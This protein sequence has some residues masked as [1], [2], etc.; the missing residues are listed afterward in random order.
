M[1]SDHPFRFAAV[2]PFTSPATWIDTARRMEALGYATLLS[3]DHPSRLGS[4][5]PLGALLLAAS[6]TTRL[7]VGTHVLV[8]DFRNP[9]MLAQ[10][11][12]LLDAVSDGRFELGLGTG[13]LREDYTALGIA[14]D[15][16]GARV[17]RL[18]EAITLIKRLFREESVTF[19][20]DHYR[21]ENVQL[22][23]RPARQ[24]QPLLFI[25]G[26][27]KR[28]LSLAG[29]EADIVSFDPKGTAAGPKDLA[30]TTPAV[31][32]EQLSW[33]RAAA[34]PRFAALELH[35]LVYVVAVTEQR[36]AAAEAI[37]QLLAAL[38]PTMMINTAL[39][40]D[41]VLASPRFLIGSVE[42]IVEQLQERRAQYGI[43][44]I[45]ILSGFGGFA[46]IETFSP[47]VA[48]LAGS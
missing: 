17:G 33:V 10:Q 21:V 41:E 48:R 25:G 24:P 43:S 2:M 18:E 8:N 36:Q 7:R 38:P 46:D 12:V 26:G 42:Q 34:G 6:A 19:A 27:G 22:T 31:L 5:D 47:V 29:R 39:R 14:Y 35:L 11:A 1:S 23:P 9:V 30:T 40:V 13:S 3:S 15:P 20:G 16:P 32:A 4:V 37:V 44:Y 45:S 28:I